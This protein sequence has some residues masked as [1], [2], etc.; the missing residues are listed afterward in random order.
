MLIGSTFVFNWVAYLYIF[1]LK[2]SQ[3]IIAFSPLIA[4]YFADLVGVLYARLKE[5]IKLA[6]IAKFIFMVLLIVMAVETWKINQIKVTWTNQQT[7]DYLSQTQ[8]FIPK[9]AYV[10]DLF[11]E[12]MFYKDPYFICCLPY[13]QYTEAFKIKLPSLA[14]ALESTRTKYIYARDKDRLTVL[15]SREENFIRSNYLPGLEDPVIYVPGKKIVFE[16]QGEK[17]MEIIID[18]KYELY[19]SNQKIVA[20]NQMTG[21]F[22][23]DKMIT[24]NPFYF[25]R[26]KYKIKV[27][28]KGEL[29]VIYKE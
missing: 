22:V 17:E 26:G 11:G 9:G 6:V 18:G 15:P 7:A 1:S 19:W 12:S 16:N 8:K 10:F 29:K 4:F 27:A 2:H 5:N 13:G 28:D 24:E 14:Q 25:S 23:N 20:G 3:Y 21:L